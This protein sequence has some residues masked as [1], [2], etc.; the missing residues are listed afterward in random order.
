[1]FLGEKFIA[2][3]MEIFPAGDTGQFPAP[4]EPPQHNHRTTVRN[5]DIGIYHRLSICLI[6]PE[7]CKACPR[8]RHQKTAPFTHEINRSTYVTVKELDSEY[9]F[10]R[11]H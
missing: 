3:T 8:R 1:M 9:L 2:Q 6:L 10:S 4:E 7:S 11:R 5:G